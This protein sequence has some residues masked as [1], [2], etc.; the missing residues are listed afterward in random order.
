MSLVE[1]ISL[2]DDRG[3]ILY[4]ANRKVT[5]FRGELEQP[6]N[7][8]ANLQYKVSWRGGPI[9]RQRCRH[10]LFDPDMDIEEPPREGVQYDREEGKELAQKTEKMCRL[11]IPL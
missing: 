7:N 8:P 3:D 1:L 9:V 5:A 10:Y 6:K 2:K 4:Q 11:S